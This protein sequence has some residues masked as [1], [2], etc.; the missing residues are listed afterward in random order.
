MSREIKYTGIVLKKQAFGEADEIITF[1]T[2]EAGKVRALAKSIKLAKAKLQNSL[3]TFFLTSVV[4]SGRGDLPKIIHSVVSEH[5]SEI[6]ENFLALKYAFFA[7]ELMLKFTPDEQKNEKLFK[8]FYNFLK[9]LNSS[10]N[11]YELGLLKFKTEFLTLSGFSTENYADLK[12][13][14]LWFQ[15][16]KMLEQSEF[17]NLPNRSLVVKEIEEL[18]S[19]LSNFIKFHMEREIKSEFIFKDMV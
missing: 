2:L 8:L 14:K 5:F 7:G 3:Q 6:R 10:A 16:C 11:D 18:Q 4:L 1:F 17:I 15:Q 13:K 19:F 12:D 9:F